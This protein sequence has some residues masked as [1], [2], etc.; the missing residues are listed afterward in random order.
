MPKRI[1]ITAAKNVAK[2][3]D[4]HQVILVAWDGSLAHVV[5]YGKSL[6]DCDQAAQCGNLVKKALGYPDIMCNIE[7]ARVKKLRE[8]IK[9]LKSLCKF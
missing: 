6:I 1:P 2:A 8:E 4:L 7:T 9:Y 5:T 3:Y